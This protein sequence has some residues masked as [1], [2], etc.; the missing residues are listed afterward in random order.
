MKKLHIFVGV[1][2]ISLAV[3]VSA[4]TNWPRVYGQPG[5]N[6]ASSSGKLRF[7]KSVPPIGSRQDIASVEAAFSR[8][9]PDALIF[10]ADECWGPSADPSQASL[11][12]R[13]AKREKALGKLWAADLV[14]DKEIFYEK[15]L[16][17]CGP[18]TALIKPYFKSRIQ[19][20]EW[21]EVK[22][23]GNDA[24]VYA[25]GKLVAYS[26]SSA[27]ENSLGQ[28]QVHMQRESSQSPWRL[29]SI[30]EHANESGK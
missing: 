6:A 26:E 10:G 2:C 1:I 24:R 19:V 3:V 8:L 28:F 12:S 4:A 17:T 16:A 15:F 14:A 22:V 18:E 30:V 13:V 23:D 21:N 20:D 27:M 7:H 11:P 25:S 9:V 29:L 5:E